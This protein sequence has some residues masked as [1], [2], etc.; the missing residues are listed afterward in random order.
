MIVLTGDKVIRL[1]RD[2]ERIRHLVYISCQADGPAMNNF[3]TLCQRPNRGLKSEPFQLRA[4]IPV[5][6][7]PHTNHCELVLSFHR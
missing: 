1:L 3:V 2:N 4:A 7:F 6:M 5:D